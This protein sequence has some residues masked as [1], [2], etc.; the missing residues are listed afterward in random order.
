M[1][2]DLNRFYLDYNFYPDSSNKYKCVRVKYNDA[3]KEKD[4]DVIGYELDFRFFEKVLPYNAPD[5][6]NTI[7]ELEIYEMNYKGTEF[8]TPLPMNLKIFKLIEC[9]VSNIVKL[10]PKLEALICWNNHIKKLP[11]LPDT[12]KLIWCSDNELIKLPKLPNGLVVLHCSDNKFTR[13][14][15]LPDSIVTLN[16]SHNNIKSIDKLPNNLIKLICHDNELEKFPDF[17]NRL[18]SIE[19][20]NNE[21]KFLPKLPDSLTYLD[22]HKNKNL[23]ELPRLPN[24]LETLYCSKCNLNYIP[25]MPILL[26]DLDCYNNNLT[27]LPKCSKMLEELNCSHNKLTELPKLYDNIK[28]LAC[29]NNQIIKLQPDLPVKNLKWLNINNNQ[30]EDLPYTV[31]HIIIY[32]NKNF[33]KQNYSF[34]GSYVNYNSEI[35][36][37]NPFDK[38]IKCEINK[39]KTFEDLY[40]YLDKVAANAIGEWF[41]RCKYDPKYKYCKDR[42][43]NEHND[44]FSYDE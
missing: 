1:T 17:P 15:N 34:D 6:Y 2:N 18:N 3:Y 9:N 26:K 41:L 35:F 24:R 4:S 36:E 13:L 32:A 44:M 29:F 14:T 30:I 7:T 20:S 39:S 42:L 16:C 27:K 10:P 21:L 38:K 23:T 12:L 25:N 28:S 11:E 31:R 37:N 33:R 43:K 5:F 8:K 40:N 19:I 22:C